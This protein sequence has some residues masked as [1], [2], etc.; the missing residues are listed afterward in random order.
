MENVSFPSG[1]WDQDNGGGSLP[2]S[3]IIM[4]DLLISTTDSILL[5]Q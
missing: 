4:V 3:C 1:I 5:L 2:K